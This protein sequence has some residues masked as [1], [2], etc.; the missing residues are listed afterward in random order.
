MT[1]QAWRD[2]LGWLVFGIVVVATLV[3]FVLS[4]RGLM[5][6]AGQHGYPHGWAWVFPLSVD[7]F[8]IAGEATLFRAVHDDWT[9]WERTPAW[10]AVFCGLL[11]SVAGNAGLAWQTVIATQ[12]TKSVPPVAMTGM[13]ALGLMVLK[14]EMRPRPPRQLGAEPATSKPEPVSVAP[15]R[16]VTVREVVHT[17]AKRIELEGRRLALA[18]VGCEHEQ[19]PL[20]EERLPVAIAHVQGCLREQP[21]GNRLA[22]WTGVSR[23]TIRR[24]LNGQL[25][26]ARTSSGS[27]SQD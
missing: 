10:C 14:H 4:Y 22:A 5:D 17:K 19:L 25:Q 1:L 23:T 15:S 8:I 3:S 20:G 26:T 21:S 27:D 24:K 12:V 7:L 16:E 6:W 2:R 18:P 9:G 13:L 11:V